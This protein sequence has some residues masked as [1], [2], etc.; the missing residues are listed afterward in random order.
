MKRFNL[1][2]LFGVTTVS[3]GA[4]GFYMTASAFFVE[5]F[6]FAILNAYVAGAAIAFGFTLCYPY[7]QGL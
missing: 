6:P 3:A 7:D 2:T 1:R 5:P 4:L